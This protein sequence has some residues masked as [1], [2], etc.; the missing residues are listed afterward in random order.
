MIGHLEG[1]VRQLTPERVLL[2]VGGVG[3]DLHI[4]TS[5]YYEL[6][7]AGADSVG[8]WVHTHVRE[9]A[10]LLYGFWT[11]AERQL[12]EQL[13]AVSGIGPRLAQAVLSG[14]SP[15]DLSTAIRGGDVRRLVTIPG[16]GKKTAER[17]VLELRD[18]LAAPE[19][20]TTVAPAAGEDD[21][22]SALV[23]LGYRANQATR[24]LD[25]VRDRHADAPFAEQLRAALRWLS[26]S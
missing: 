14:M 13:I 8:L 9:D 2:G 21:L 10:F 24:A 22:H 6:E 23:N 12:F 3:Y 1:V 19:L 20:P 4:P 17:M 18:K 26:G 15:A 16:V 25:H 5:T 7:R 11:E